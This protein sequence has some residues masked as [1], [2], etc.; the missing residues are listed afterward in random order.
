[1]DKERILREL[2]KGAGYWN[3]WRKH[4]A[5]Q[6]IVLDGIHLSG[7]V[8]DDYDLSKVL[9]RNSHIA[10]CSFRNADLIL[11]N[12]QGS[13]LHNNDFSHAKLIA[14]NFSGATLHACNIHRA[15]M[16][17]AI[18]RNAR[19]E[20]MD[21][22]GHDISG[23]VLRNISLAGS[24]LAGQNLSRVDFSNSNL[25]GVNFEGADLTQALLA[26]ANLVNA[27]FKFAKLNSTVFKGADL[28]GV[29]LG[30]LD[31]YK[32]DFT[33]ANLVRCD[34]RNAQLGKTKFN[35]ANISGA[36][37][38]KINSQGWAID[39]I[40]C[41]HAF[42][43]EAG[44]QKTTYRPHEF[45]RIFAEAITIELRYP[46]RLSDHELATLPIFIE[47]LAAVHWGTILR[48][49]SITDVAGGA[50]VKFVVEELG[51]HSPTELKEQLQSEAE[52]IQ[53]AQLTLRTNTQLHMQL[54]EKI[55]AIREEFWP[56]L[57]ELAADHE[58]DQVRNLTIL[59]MDLKG[60]S[61]WSEEE[62]SERLSL[63]R[64][65]VK[66]VLK[67]WSADHPNMEG[68]SLRV[69]FKNATAGVSCACMIRSILTAAGF[70]MRIGVELGEVAVIHNEITNIPDL[71]GIAVSMAARMEA[72]A[73]PGE[74]LVSQRVRHHAEPSGLFSF[75]PRRVPLKK[76]IGNMEPGECVECFAVE[77]LGNLQELSG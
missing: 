63:F 73:D 12:F 33:G 52:R 59:F 10:H 4:Q 34:L 55:G 6:E 54:K 13:Q 60:F 31:L 8:L 57:L 24:N 69:T 65:L 30:G 35:N 64:G 70:Q 21:F 76:A 50:L 49:K 11:A 38:W 22:S 41:D 26:G 25:E 19:L 75:A 47:H 45:E 29:D 67:K 72:A 20:N 2:E 15:N 53:L 66:P 3:Q 7:M 68:D 61:R 44:K 74:V 14:A 16:L 39:R 48:L 28:Q 46:Y 23:L 51:S 71:E 40:V 37:L 17:T 18:T 5:N 9:L 58:K 77:A 32:A 56:R 27:R 36:R 62:L 1:M 42:W 43:D